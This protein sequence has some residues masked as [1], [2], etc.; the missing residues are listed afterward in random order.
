MG[1]ADKNIKVYLDCL[2]G[3]MPVPGGGSASALVGALGCGLLSM[4]AHF[5]LL[6]KGFN[7]YK[8]RAQRALKK[9]ENLRSRFTL[10]IDDDAK[11]YKALASVF[12]KHSRDSADL[13]K[14]LKKA[15][16]PPQRVC[17]YCYEA[18]IVAL[19]LSYTGKRSLLPDIVS[20]IHNLNA[21]FE[22][23]LININANLHF[24]K[25]RPFVRSKTKACSA[26]QINMKQ[27][28]AKVLSVVLER[29]DT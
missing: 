2:A 10:I 27:I 25:N 7:G 29:M 24:I 3:P 9:S 6:S 18:A 19:E 12:K 20:A 26:L 15:I 17:D 21:A 16:I 1:Y 28:K 5:T 11:A 22:T 8:E 13:Q 14:A 4:V 23:G